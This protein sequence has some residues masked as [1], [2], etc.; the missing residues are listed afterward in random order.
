MPKLTFTTL[1]TSDMNEVEQYE[2]AFFRAFSRY[3]PDDPTLDIIWNVN[4]QEKRISTKISYDD[5]EIYVARLDDSI[6]G[7]VAVNYN[8]HRQ[9]QLEMLGFSIDKSQKNICE[10]L[11]LFNLQ[12]F[13]GANPIALLLRDYGFDLFKQKGIEKVFGT[14]DAH[15]V[16]GYS[17]LGFEIVE[18]KEFGTHRE[19]LIA[20]SW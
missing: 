16:R 14:C 15:T 20:K 18:M 5:Q 12:V 9:W 3:Y 19:Y 17:I 13:H 4:K 7:G 6:I 2:K 10:G 1:D 11:A 8:L